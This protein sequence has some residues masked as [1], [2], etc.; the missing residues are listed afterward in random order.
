VGNFV[1]QK[2]LKARGQSAFIFVLGKNCFWLWLWMTANPF[3][4]AVGFWQK[5]K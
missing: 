1:A 4:W 2:Q 5:Q 3:G